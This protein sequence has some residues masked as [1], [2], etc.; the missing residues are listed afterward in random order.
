MAE[1]ERSKQQYVPRLLTIY[2]DQIV[3]AMMKEFSIANALAVPRI[4]KVVINM[5]VKEGTVDIK[6]LEQLQHE[7]AMITG[8]QPVI[9]RS[10]KAISKI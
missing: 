6:L 3:P 7:L 5:G 2:R 8:Q 10:K 9:T 4:E 1:T